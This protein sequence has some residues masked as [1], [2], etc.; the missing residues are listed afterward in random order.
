[1]ISIQKYSLSSISEPELKLDSDILS[2][3]NIPITYK[4]ATTGPNRLKWIP[5]I[6]RELSSL[7]KHKVWTILPRE[8]D[9][10]VVPVKWIFAIKKDGTYKAR[11]VAVGCRDTEKYTPA[12]KATP[13]PSSDTVRWLIAHVSYSKIKLI[14]LDIITAFIHADIDRLKYVSLGPGVPGNRKNQVCKLNRAL[15]GLVTAPKCWYRTFD[16]KLRSYGFERSV[17]E[18]CL[19]TKTVGPFT[20]IALV[21]VDDVLLACEDDALL[22]QTITQISNDFEVKNLGFPTKFLGIDVS[23]DTNKVISLSQEPFLE[24]VLRE[25]QMEDSHPVRN[26][27]LKDNDYSKLTRN[28]TNFPYKNVLGNLMWL[29]NYTRPDIAYSVNFLARFQTNPSEEHWIMLKR[30]MRYLNGTRNSGLTFDQRS[31]SILDTFVDS[32]FMDDPATKKSTTGYLIRYHGNNIAWK[33]RLQ[34]TMSKSTTHAEYIAICDAST[35]ILFLAHLIN[36]TLNMPNI[37]PIPLYEDNSACITVCE[38]TTTR[39]SLNYLEREELLVREL[40]ERNKLKPEKVISKEQIA[41]IFTKP[42]TG[43]QFKYLSSKLIRPI[44]AVENRRDSET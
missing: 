44:I 8:K 42:L 43:N 28:Q 39:T 4:E 11:L 41:D 36:E 26:P 23:V 21:Y 13:T 27:M 1:M 25:F 31:T 12:G 29:A 24:K 3:T 20:I 16:A 5:A 35:N 17:R 10:A 30:I 18:P 19:Y 32:S 33:S 15:Y 40:F 2:L 9:M 7:E 38:K 34:R 6:K 14:Q 37:F 22:T